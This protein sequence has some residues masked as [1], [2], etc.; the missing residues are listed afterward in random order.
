[1]NGQT[2]IIATAEMLMITFGFVLAATEFTTKTIWVYDADNF[3][4]CA[5]PV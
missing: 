3:I 1:M 2:L 5:K 4:P